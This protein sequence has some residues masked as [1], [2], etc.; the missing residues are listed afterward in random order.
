MITTITA[1]AVLEIARLENKITVSLVVLYDYLNLGGIFSQ[2]TM[3][4]NS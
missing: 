3:K 4:K 2:D 1:K